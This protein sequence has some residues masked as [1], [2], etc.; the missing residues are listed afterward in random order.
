MPATWGLG[1][2]YTLT[3][4]AADSYGAVVEL[5]SNLDV[6]L[7]YHTL[8]SRS[9]E[10]QTITDLS[11]QIPEAVH[12][13]NRIQFREYAIEEVG[14]IF[15]A[16]I[17]MEASS[18]VIAERVV[19]R[20]LDLTHSTSSKVS[21][22]TWA[23]V[24]LGQ[25]APDAKSEMAAL[26]QVVFNG[27]GLEVPVKT[28][29]ELLKLALGDPP[30]PNPWAR[31]RNTKETLVGKFN[32][33]EWRQKSPYARP[34]GGR[35]LPHYVW[36][37]LSDLKNWTHGKLRD[38]EGEVIS[39]PAQKVRLYTPNEVAAAIHQAHELKEVWLDVIVFTTTKVTEG[40]ASTFIAF[41]KSEV[42]GDEPPKWLKKYSEPNQLALSLKHGGSTRHTRG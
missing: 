16:T 34:G 29:E 40:K 5:P 36:K 12:T 18:D 30:P 15:R 31:D 19:S 20:L 14:D 26:S 11:K 17:T 2:K 13:A 4:L 39:N 41:T 23:L 22:D 7:I 25:Q 3:L 42:S 1:F 35:E 33:M 21:V 9:T 28:E 38:Q 6:P 27:P 8:T 37:P 10:A 24:Q 32:D